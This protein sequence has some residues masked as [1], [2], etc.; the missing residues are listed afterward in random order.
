MRVAARPSEAIE[1]SIFCREFANAQR[2][3]VETVAIL[4]CCLERGMT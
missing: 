3:D 4:R 1:N 2:R